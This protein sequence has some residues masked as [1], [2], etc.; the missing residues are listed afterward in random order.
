MELTE[1]SEEIIG[2]N[3]AYWTGRAESY[4]EIN[5][6]ELSGDSHEKWEEHLCD[7]IES[8]FPDREPSE[9]SVLEVGC[10]PGFLSILLAEAGYRVSAIDLTAAMLEKAKENSADA[11]V[12][13]K[14]TFYEMNALDLEF[15]G[16]SFDVVVS[17]NLTWDLPEPEGAYE[18][19]TK[20][21]KPGGLLLNFDANWYHYLFFDDALEGFEAD[22]IN[23]QAQGILDRNRGDNFDVME[24]IARMVP[25]S[26]ISR[27]KWD[28]DVLTGLG[29]NC[30]TDVDVWKKLWTKEDVVNFSSTPLFMVSAVK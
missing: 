4:S 15:E 3:R 22:R 9:I 19:W 18:E 12:L 23:S 11:G 28:V 7:Q 17:R 26:K 29:M 8:R 20:V 30:T 27:P 24:D 2:E 21:L 5:R 10:G 25:L 6:T 14:I 16:E 1:T 13:D